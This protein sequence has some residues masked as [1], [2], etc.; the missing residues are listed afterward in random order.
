[1]S[2][3]EPNLQ[4]AL[5]ALPPERVVAYDVPRHWASGVQV[6]A[7][8][9]FTFLVFREQNVVSVDDGEVSFVLKNVASVVLPTAV[10]RQ[11]RDILLAQL[12][13]MSA[14]DGGE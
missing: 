13:V 11:L 14:P 9:D 8:P 12:P 1:M 2:E 4:A 6:V 5:R 7:N 3:V 10:A